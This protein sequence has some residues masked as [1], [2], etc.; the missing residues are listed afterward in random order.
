M[1]QY[2]IDRINELAHIAKQRNLTEEELAERQLLREE[3]LASLRASL[4]SQ[5]DAIEF[6]DEVNELEEEAEEL[7][8]ELIET[9]AEIDS[10]NFIS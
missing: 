8:E 6:V 1:E 7:E 4:K 5:L 3:F 9:A 2:K 10:N